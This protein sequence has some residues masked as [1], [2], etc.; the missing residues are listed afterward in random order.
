MLKE[1]EDGIPIVALRST[2]AT[3][4]IVC[5]TKCSLLRFLSGRK[6][7]RDQGGNASQTCEKS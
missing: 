5:V 4:A 2:A 7:H 1:G 6:A 3:E